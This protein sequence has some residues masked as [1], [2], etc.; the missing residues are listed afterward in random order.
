M[1]RH[2]DSLR[3]DR[4]ALLVVD[5]QTRLLP[6]MADAEQ[7]VA[8]SLRLATAAKRLSVPVLVTEQ[9][10]EKLG[11]TAPELLGVLGD[12]L[13]KTPAISKSCFSCCGAQELMDGLRETPAESVV[14]CGIEAHVCVQQTALDLLAH[15][16]RPYVCADAVSSRFEIDR[17]TALAR[18]QAA[19]A[20]ITTSESVLFEW[21]VGAEHEAFRDV[22]KLLK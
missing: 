15:G 13:G 21:L 1:T 22:Q 11:P 20:I 5:V 8:R 10:P 18:L 9:V 19:G 3:V 17:T 16:L 14:L 12:D 4:S 7:V 2:P 6:A